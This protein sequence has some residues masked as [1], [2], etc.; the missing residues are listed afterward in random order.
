MD[1][2]DNPDEIVNIVSGT[3]SKGEVKVQKSEETGRLLI[4]KWEQVSIWILWTNFKEGCCNECP[5][6]RVGKDKIVHINAIYAWVIG[7]MSSSR[8]IDIKDVFSHKLR[9]VPTS[10]FI[11]DGMKNAKNKSSSWIIQ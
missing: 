6:G 8:D 10:M 1:P 2:V 9:S 7:L 5:V 11:E 4:K 3:I